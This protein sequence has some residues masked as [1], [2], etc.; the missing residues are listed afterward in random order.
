M[1]RHR[2]F[3]TQRTKGNTSSRV[4]IYLS[5]FKRFDFTDFRM[6]E[7]ESDAQCP[8][9]SPHSVPYL[10]TRT[11][12]RQTRIKSLAF[13]FPTLSI[14]NILSRL[15]LAT[16]NNAMC[17]WCD[18]TQMIPQVK[19]VTAG[20]WYLNS[21]PPL[22]RRLLRYRPEPWRVLFPETGAGHLA[23]L[24]PS[25]NGADSVQRLCTDTRMS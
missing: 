18:R 20:R 1:W 21:P 23:H 13:F 3:V 2:S 24:D 10:V 7:T 9:L 4:N 11:V 16:F 8:C 25:V 14:A 15:N 5:W 19:S 17:F 22:P 12:K 6:N